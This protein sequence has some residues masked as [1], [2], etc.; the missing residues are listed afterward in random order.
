MVFINDGLP[1]DQDPI[2]SLQTIAKYSPT[3][4]PIGFAASATNLLKAV[5]AWKLE[6]GITVLSLEYLLS[7]R[8][9]FNTLT[10]SLSIRAINGLAPIL[11]VLWALSPLGG[12]ASLRVM[13]SVPSTAT[14]PW[15]FEYLEFMS[16]ASHSGQYTSSGMETLPA[17][18]GAFAAALSGPKSVKSASQDLFGNL[19]IPMIESFRTSSGE[20]G[21]DGYYNVDLDPNTSTV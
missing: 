3:L 6:R 18:H 16:P 14:E 2:P 15:P 5:A 21:L 7:C 8:T 1:V 9:V 13:D 19:K 4:F 17:I 12:Q 11:F 20:P 10:T